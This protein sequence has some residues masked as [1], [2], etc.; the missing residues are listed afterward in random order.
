MR[1]TIRRI[2]GDIRARKHV[3][4]YVVSG[5]AIIFAILTTIGDIVPEQLKTAAILAAL[6]LLVFNISTPDHQLAS[7]DDI[8]NDRTSFIPLGDRLKG[9]RKFWIY[10]PSAINVLSP[11]NLML[12][13][14][15]ILAYPDGEFRVL[16]QDPAKTAAVQLLVRQLDEGLT[17]RMR[18]L[19]SDI[20]ESIARLEKVA[21]WKGQGA[22]AYRLLDY[23]PGFSL[24]VV[25]PDKRDGYILVEFFGF[26][27]E[28]VG[29]RMHIQLRRADSERWF[30]YWVG[31]FEHMWNA[32]RL[33]AEMDQ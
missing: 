21:T 33:P 23:G 16:V 32:A 25:D 3:D 26:H 29:N 20:A 10:G 1:R 28:Q 30:T 24:M 22:F 17:F 5:L 8:L 18:D 27:N 13:K 14:D 11:E 15:E 31:Q 12:I 6:G 19:P 9:V 4:V 7:A 2:F